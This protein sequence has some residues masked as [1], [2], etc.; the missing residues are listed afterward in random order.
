MQWCLLRVTWAHSWS[1]NKV[2]FH[3]EIQLF[4]MSYVNETSKSSAVVDLLRKLFYMAAALQFDFSAILIDTKSNNVADS[5]SLIDCNKF[6]KLVLHADIAMTHPTRID[7]WAHPQKPYTFVVQFLKD[8][9]DT[10]I[11]CLQFFF[12]QLPSFV[13]VCN[14]W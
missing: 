13:D 8:D 10:N 9:S 7:A 5:L 1:G 11:T 2:L 3:C 14:L 4:T 12:I 6:W